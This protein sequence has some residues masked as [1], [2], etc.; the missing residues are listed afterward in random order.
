MFLSK[1]E[2]TELSFLA[3]WQYDIFEQR[4]SKIFEAHVDSFGHFEQGMGEFW[5]C[6]YQ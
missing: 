3:V 1:Q 4:C 2:E 6:R 5:L